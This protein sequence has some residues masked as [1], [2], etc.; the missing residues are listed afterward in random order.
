MAATLGAV[1]VHATSVRSEGMRR[2]PARVVARW[3]LVS[4]ALVAVVGA[5]F[6]LAFAGSPARLAEGVTVAGVEVGG[7]TRAEARGLLEQRYDKVA[8]VP[9][10]FTAGD[11]R[12]P[13]SAATLGVEADWNAALG[14]AAREGEGF[15]PVRGF[16]RLHAR[17]FGAEI[18]PPVQAYNAALDYKLGRLADAIDRD[19]LEAH[20][21]RHGLQIEVVPEQSGR[22][23]DRDRAAS[24][25]V[26]ALAQLDRGAQ[27]PLPVR[28]DPATVTAA[29]LA[30][31]QRQAELALS[32]PVRLEY[33]G[34]RWKLPR[35]R[36]AELLSLPTAGATK[37]AIAGPGAEA[38]FEKLRKR[39]EHAPVDATF[40]VY[41]GGIR[42]VS[43]K[44]GLGVNVPATAKALLA[45]AIKPNARTA[46]LAVET[47][48]AERSAAEA[49]AM[50]ITGVVASYHT[51]YGGI[52][53]RLHNVALVAQLIDGTLIAP[54]KTFSF[55]ATTGERTPEK[56]FLE[57]PV[58][59]N[60]ELQ[61]GLG[62]GVC[63]VST[64]VF[65][66]AYEA[67]LPIDERTNHALYISHYP[68]G[69]DATVNYPDQDLKFTN[70]TANWLLLRTFVG[71]G[72]LTVNLYGTPQNRQVESVAQ[73]LR[74]VGQ[75]QI[76]RIPDPT[77]LKGKFFVESYG[78][79]A[80]ATSV[81]RIVRSASGAVLHENTWY[82]TYRS[83]PKIVHVGTKE[84]PKPKPKPE[85]KPT[86]TAPTE[87]TPTPPPA[88]E[89]PPTPQP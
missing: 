60:G 12:F 55:N 40:E 17:F 69:R 78:E 76:R 38:W 64:T 57:A 51:T 39:V 59:I 30:P 72:S 82:S 79:P 44:D 53:N 71:P 31:A 42:I 10:V 4:A 15:G 50:G 70:D 33:E 9:V 5:I 85:P 54:G 47:T 52:A 18:A 88:D 27:V 13:I 34:T 35:W 81:T 62:G 2:S 48:K 43:D 61:T 3:V 21:V 49:Q 66:A 87:T 75:P 45:A 14:A 73:P 8:H 26:R 11:E 24:T 46:T 67:G 83:E 65:N 37:L 32:A 22:Q 74:V 84:P 7:L 29:D 16:R 56:G 86:Q 63:Q 20:L 80:R 58:I 1:G 28:V 68:L 36:I 19:H 89:P 25:I 77:M 6:G 23:L 41:P